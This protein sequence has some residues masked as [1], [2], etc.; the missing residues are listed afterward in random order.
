[1]NLGRGPSSSSLAFVCPFCI[2]LTRVEQIFSLRKWQR[3]T[4]SFFLSFLSL[5]FMMLTSSSSKE[6]CKLASAAA[7]SDI[8][9][10]EEGF[11]VTYSGMVPRTGC[12]AAAHAAAGVNRLLT[13]NSFKRNWLCRAAALCCFDSSSSV[14]INCRNLSLLANASARTKCLRIVCSR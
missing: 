5:S 7:S 2:T 10:E 13:L 14:G 9:G 12:A 11:F 4:T 3:S 6:L 8:G 1:M